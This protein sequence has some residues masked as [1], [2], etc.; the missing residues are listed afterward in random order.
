MLYIER[1]ELWQF[2]N[3]TQVQ[4]N[5][6]NQI[7]LIV[8]Q[9]GQGKSNLLEAIYYLSHG[10]SN[11]SSRDTELIRHARGGLLDPSVEDPFLGQGSRVALHLAGG[12]SLEARFQPDKVTS[13]TG[14]VSQK[15]KTQFLIDSQRCKSRSE[16]IGRLP[17]VSFYLSDL[18]IV[19]GMPQSRRRWVDL[20][21]VQRLPLHLEHLQVWKKTLS[22][23]SALLKQM[24]FPSPQSEQV[25]LLDVLNQQLATVAWRILSERLETLRILQTHL[26]R[27][28]QAL[29][30][31]HDGTP[32]VSY[33]VHNWPDAL[34]LL[35]T[36]NERE[37]IQACLLHLREIMPQELRRQ[38][39]AWGVHRDDIGIHFVENAQKV[40]VTTYASQGQQRSVVIALKL[41]ELAMLE[42]SLGKSPIILLDDIMAELDADRQRQLLHIFPQTSQVFL[43]TPYVDTHHHFHSLLAEKKTSLSSWQVASGEIRLL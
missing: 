15:W 12:L 17:S 28:Y 9:N 30:Q 10:R 23:K 35:E 26:P 16:M 21:T 41:A 24:D 42:N 36:V 18:E 33:T 5:G 14:F 19:R 38:S 8:G 1:L 39:V 25:H 31:G 27:L 7:N 32:T 34:T 20:A 4:W 29:S 6:L 22:E 37:W 13:P 3:F 40:D 11:R 2:R 43:T